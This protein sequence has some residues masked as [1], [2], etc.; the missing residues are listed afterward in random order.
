MSHRKDPTSPVEARLPT[1]HGLFTAK[2]FPDP[3]QPNL[4]HVALVYGEVD[5]SEPPLVRMHSECLTGDVFGSLRCDCG[6][7]LHEALRR[8]VKEERGVLL[9]LRQEGRGIGL[10]NK[11]RAYALQDQGFDTVEAN[12]HLGFPDDLRDYSFAGEILRRLGVK[13]LRLLT[14]NPRKMSALQEHGIEI[15]ERVPLIVET[16][17][18]NEDYL[19][20]KKAKLGHMLTS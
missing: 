15:V 18:E 12:Q 5:A 17:A 10:E 1:G 3:Q 16:N 20:T 4:H 14:N 2:V 11:M 19:A 9:Y 8:I 6:P 13:R 7:Q